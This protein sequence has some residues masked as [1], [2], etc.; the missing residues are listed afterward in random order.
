MDLDINQKLWISMYTVLALF[1]VEYRA[2][3]ISMNII[4]YFLRYP[5]GYESIMDNNFDS[6]PNRLSNPD[7]YAHL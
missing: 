1:S 2:Y 4:V 5:A 7:I 6:W 3:K